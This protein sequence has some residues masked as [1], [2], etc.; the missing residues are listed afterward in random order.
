MIH[1]FSA[2]PIL[3]RI[4][5]FVIPGRAVRPSVAAADDDPSQAVSFVAR[6]VSLTLVVAAFCGGTSVHAANIT[7]DSGGADDNWSTLDNWSD[8]ASPTGDDITFDNTG[9]AAGTTVTSIVDTILS[10]NSLNFRQDNTVNHT[11]SISSGQT[12]T[13]AG[14]FTPTAGEATAVLF[15]QPSDAGTTAS[16]TNLSGLGTFTVNSA[17]SHF[18]VGYAN[19]SGTVTATVNMSGLSNFNAT[20]D[21]FGVGRK[22]TTSSNASRQ[23]AGVLTLAKNSTI[24][25]NEISVGSTTHIDGST[26]THNNGG[27]STLNLG[28]GGSAVNNLYADKMSFGIGKAAGNM[29][30]AAGVVG[31]DT[32]EI[33][34]KNTTGAVGTFEIAVRNMSSS[35]GTTSGTVNFGA[36]KVDA[37]IT[38]L[39]VGQWAN[40]AGTSAVNPTGTFT[41]GTNADS[42]VTVTTL[43]LAN[44]GS[45]TSLGAAQVVTGNLNVTG[46]VFSATTV[47]LATGT[48]TVNLTKTANLTVDGGTFRFGTFGAPTG[49]N[50]VTINFNS[51]TV[52]SIDA[53]NRTLGLAYNLGKAGG[54]TTVAFGQASGGTGTITLNGAGTL[55]GN[56]TVETVRDT[57]LG[58]ALGGAFSLTKTGTGTLRLNGVNTLG[59]VTV[60]GGTLFTENS[61]TFGHLS[62]AAAKTFQFGAQDAAYTININGLSGAGTVQTTNS[63]GFQRNLTL[64]NNDATADFSGVLTQ[65]G[66]R[67][68][69]LTKVGAG[70]Q[71][72]SGAVANTQGGGT[73]VG[74]DT[75]VQAGTM[76]LNKTA[77]IALP[78]DVFI[79]G[80]TLQLSGTG[81]NQI[82]DAAAVSM[83]SGAFDLN[84]RSETIGAF[85]LTAAGTTAMTIADGKTLTTT[86]AVTIGGAAGTTNLSLTGA[87]G[88]YAATAVGG[89]ATNANFYIGGGGTATGTVDMS[90]LGAFTAN[91]GTGTLAIG[92]GS[93]NGS[94]AVP[95]TAILAATSSITATKVS[96]G[97]GFG[98]TTNASA[99][100]LRL[101]SGAN[102]LNTTDLYIGVYNNQGRGNTGT[103]LNFNTTT[104]TLAL[105]GLAGGSTRANVHIGENQGGSTGNAS[106][107]SFNLGGSAST[108][109]SGGNAD[110]MIGALTIS[111][112]T[113]GNNDTS[114]MTFRSGIMDVNTLV[115]G[116]FTG[117]TGNSAN[118]TLTL[119]GGTVVFNTGVTLGINTSGNG[120]GAATLNVAGAAVTATPGI[121]MGNQTAGT[122]N[123]NVNITGGSLT[124]GSHITTVG[125]TNTTLTLGGG[126]L[127]MGGF[128]IGT[129]LAAIDTFTINPAT[130]AT[131]MNVG[132]IN[133]TAGI[134]K[135]GA[136]TLTLNANNYA[137]PTAI[138]A[139]TVHIDSADDL[140]DSSATNTISL[141]TGT[142]RSTANSYDLGTT[143]EITLAGVGTIQS[144]AGTLTV[145]GDVTNGANGLTL[146]GAGNIA[147]TGVIGAGATPTG[148]LT[149]GSSTVGANVTLSGNN[150]FTGNVGFGG[151]NVQPQGKLTITHSGALGVGPKTVTATS[152]NNTSAGIHLQNDI[153]LASNISFSTSGYAITNDSGNNTVNGNIAMHS[154]NGNT[155]ITS[156]SGL[157]TINGNITAG[158]TSRHLE[159]KGDGDGVIN[160][161][162]SNGNTPDLTIRKSAGLG[163]WTLTGNNTNT[164]TTTI[165]A[166]TLRIGAASGAATSGTL[167][168]SSSILND[169]ALI[170]RR[171]NTTEQDL[172][173]A[174][175]GSGSVAYEGSGSSNESQYKVDNA[176]GYLGGTTISNSRVNLTNATGMGTGAVLINSGGQVFVNAAVTVAN[177]MTIS[178]NGWLESAG[179]LG[180]LRLR[181]G[182]TVSG[183]ITLAGNSRVTGNSGT[184]T[185]SG[186]ISGGFAL[187]IGEDTTTGTLA[188]SGSNSY[189]GE[190][191]LSYR[192]LR[193]DSASALPGGIAA[194][195]G[196]SSLN[197]NGGVLGL[198]HGDFARGTGTG[199]AEV[200][201]TNSGG[202]AAFGTDRTVNLGGAGATAIWNSGSFVPTGR[203]LILGGSGAAGTLIFENPIDLG[204]ATRTL[205]ADDGTASVD[206]RLTGILS[207]AGG[208]SKSGAGTLELTADNSFT[209]TIGVSA[210]TLRLAGAAGSANDSSGVA[211]SGGGTLLLDNTTNLGDRL[212]DTGT[213]SLAGGTLSFY[214]Q[215]A[216]TTN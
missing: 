101:G 77:A 129:A 12:L 102:T 114:S 162:I 8:N 167:F 22:G 42:T 91:L 132:S 103:T 69:V 30:F 201:W 153:T 115:M 137:G 76:I 156:T 174:I 3:E 147:M 160:G 143:R 86:G 215:G 161:V 5:V 170:F 9:G 71:T 62:V 200:K 172:A 44:S 31:T 55:L 85:T 41:M 142:L 81:D 33:R 75:Y 191:K 21:I 94:G 121:V 202:F 4:R 181:D 186:D 155:H 135:T 28:S 92:N 35:S 112:R 119:N 68:L 38:N 145:S 17:A 26:G 45:S 165:S 100:T 87:T 210:G 90:G 40:G 125:A 67:A 74:F 15:G 24:T 39:N 99:Y 188:L 106:G 133:G 216:A 177:P 113:A 60:S 37:L 73:G 53:T 79:N 43:N 138:N 14:S 182:S 57:T 46:G 58:G 152:A 32:V 27:T 1:H 131:L 126:T 64:G 176:S 82:A 88:T 56:T 214:H 159:L 107:G 123:S 149:I 29:N 141:N 184:S 189:T 110:L 173:G 195:G 120:T 180:A 23:Q 140:G 84:G 193:L 206:G 127:D 18:L 109:L 25:A 208:I 78:G 83:S 134:T 178:G 203:A 128:S 171:T 205:Q 151:N 48:A 190:T 7:W 72:L 144:D 168:Y 212:K 157:L 50:A 196:T 136:G 124:L 70:A 51:G 89:G 204:T 20:V 80:G 104:G 16:T 66:N 164:G 13:V 207:G 199:A 116:N 117:T 163:T 98:N 97:A 11:L 194:S 197:F 49:T 59:D 175:G 192:I 169:A 111:R 148:G 93:T 146:L 54:G 65:A 95:Y 209:G 158:T 63:G 213:V 187:E 36:G 108:G 150:L 179:Q 130:S 19:A 52:S 34:G 154:G 47:N 185:I 10:I 166:G 6:A 2:K 139:G 198:N 105:R 211:V 61:S 96:V 183:D 122:V 118:G